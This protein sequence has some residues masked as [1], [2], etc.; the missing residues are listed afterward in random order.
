[1]PAIARVIRGI[2][3]PFRDDV[4][5]TNVNWTGGSKQEKEREREGGALLLPLSQIRGTIRKAL[6][7][8]ALFELTLV[9][10]D[11]QWSSQ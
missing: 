2:A 11:E 7:A 6:L 3:F 8:E 5:L 9:R 10:C 1:M 4:A